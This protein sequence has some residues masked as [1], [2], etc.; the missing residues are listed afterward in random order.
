MGLA[1]VREW[2]RACEVV[3]KDAAPGDGQPLIPGDPE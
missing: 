1:D 2:E 3:T